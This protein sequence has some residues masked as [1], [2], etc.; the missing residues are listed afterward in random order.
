MPHFFTHIYEALQ[1]LGPVLLSLYAIVAILCIWKSN[2]RINNSCFLIKITRGHNFVHDF[3][4]LSGG[5]QWH[6]DISEWHLE[7]FTGV[8]ALGLVR[9]IPLSFTAKLTVSSDS[10]SKQ[11]PAGLHRFSAS[12]NIKIK[13]N[14]FKCGFQ[15]RNSY[16]QG[17]TFGWFS[18]CLNSNSAAT[19]NFL[20]CCN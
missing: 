16:I 5:F 15:G 13:C 14:N 12:S 11:I 3:F 4:F 17:C 7:N 6:W 20:C 18:I 10:N 19:L 2:V 8:S 1:N 9:T